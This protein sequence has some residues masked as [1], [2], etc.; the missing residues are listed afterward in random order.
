[1]TTKKDISGANS[2]RK[3]K[4]FNKIEIIENDNKEVEKISTGIEILDS[5]LIG[6]YL[7]GSHSIIYGN[8]DTGKTTIASYLAKTT[9][10]EKDKALYI[11]TESKNPTNWI[12]KIRNG[13]LTD[14]NI[15]QTKFAENIFNVIDVNTRGSNDILE[16]AKEPFSRT[17]ILDSINSMA[18]VAETTAGNT[19]MR[20]ALLASKITDYFNNLTNGVVPNRCTLLFLGQIRVANLGTAF[21]SD[22]NLTGGHAL[23]HNAS[24]MLFIKR[25]SKSEFKK[26]HTLITKINELQSN[27]KRFKIST[28]RVVK[29][30]I[31]G[32][33]ENDVFFIVIQDNV[34][35]NQ[36]L[37]LYENLKHYS[38]IFKDDRC[39]YIKTP[40]KEEQEFTEEHRKDLDKYYTK[41]TK[42]FEKEIVSIL[43]ENR[44]YFIDYYKSKR[45]FY[46]DHTEETNFEYLKNML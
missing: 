37:T 25:L 12:S 33:S 38:I 16:I 23:K 41:I 9:A 19:N 35:I 3:E 5:F 28:L 13:D 17:V 21:P 18:N 31:S 26:N 42:N 1:M 24:L 30:H 45:I 34:G 4:E 14:I 2:K 7:R 39:I 8:N 11:S 32:V 20:V 10:D 40:N 29:S 6:G 15:S 44:K 22:T 46:R 43:S 36:D 27:D